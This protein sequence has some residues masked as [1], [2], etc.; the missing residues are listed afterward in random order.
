M[1]RLIFGLFALLYFW[2]ILPAQELSTTDKQQIE[3][4]GKIIDEND[5]AV[6]GATV[7]LKNTTVGTSADIDGM[8]KIKASKGDILNVTYLGYETYEFLIVEDQSNLLIQMKPSTKELDEVVVTGMGASQRKV[9]LVGAVTNVDVAQLQ[10]P[11][12]SLNNM[13]GGRV[14][15]VITRQ[16]SGEPGLD[17][18]EFWIRGIGTFGAGQGALVLIDGMEG[19][20]SDIDPADVESF[21]ILKDASA[22]A[23]YGVRG[24]N[25][26]V[27]VTTKKGV[28]GKISITA[29]TNYTISKMGRMPKYVDAY[30]YALLANEAN[31]VRGD[32]PVYSDFELDLIR[33]Q[34]DPDLYPNVNWQDE[35]MKDTGF[36]H[37]HYISA[38][39]GGS[40]ARYFVSLGASFDDS[41]YRID[42]NTKYKPSVGYNSYNYRSNIDMDITKTTNLYLGI[43][44]YVGVR[45]T[46]GVGGDTN[47]IWA[48]MARITPLM[49]PATYSDGKLP[50]VRYKDGYIR[51]P[52]AVMNYTGSGYEERSVNNISLALNQDLSA[53][54]EGLTARAQFAYKIEKND[55]SRRS[56][57]PDMYDALGRDYRTGAL[58]YDHVI[59][60]SGVDYAE[61]TD[62][63]RNLHFESTI[64]YTKTLKKKHRIGALAYYYMS[65]ESSYPNSGSMDAIA[66]RY[67][68]LS[69]RLSY[70]FKDTYLID[71]NFGYT[72]SENFEKGK[73]FGFFPSVAGGWVPTGY[74]IVKEKLPWLDFFKIRG[75]YG[76][77]GN[78]KITDTRFPFL[79]IIQQGGNSGWG[80]I[81]SV[82]ED[83][84]GA[85]NL[86]WEKAKKMDVGVEGRLFKQ[87]VDFTVD[88][89][90]DQRDG[91]FQER[92]Q[93]PDYV[94]LTSL[95]FGNVGRMRSYGAD[96]S[97]SYTH[98]IGKDMSFAIRGNFTH[99][100]NEIQEW[101]QVNQKYEYQEYKGWPHG[102]QRGYIAEGL[103][104]DEE[105]VKHSPI[106][107]FGKYAAG[108]IKY[109]DVNGDGQI[110][111]D[112]Q[113][114]LSYGDYP[115]LMYGFG[116][117]FKYKDF[118]I[119]ALFRGV[120]N[121]D[122][123]HISEDW[124][125]G[126][127]PFLDSSVGNV[128]EMVADQKNRWTPESY[129]GDKSTENP[130][131]KFP[132]LSYSSNENNKQLSTFW[133]SNSK[134]L[135][136]QEI[137]LSY[138]LMLPQ[139][140]KIGV[141]SMDLQLT[142]YD[143]YVWSDL[144]WD[145][146]LARYNGRRY[147][148]P[149]KYTFQLYVN[150]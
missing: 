78:D 51:S 111:G 5:E 144:E 134:H 80:G 125:M 85:N 68:G 101:E 49:V 52:Y 20:L 48:E 12:T 90:N 79:T 99:S 62:S 58:Q 108:D 74:D 6:I 73:Q 82:W 23:V 97:I 107:T 64:N 113:V 128:L 119:G 149:T 30:Q 87:S 140:Q 83:R 129:S 37:S 105:D 100:V 96:G 1:K 124:G 59:R 148:I 81:N 29:R 94:G 47:A 3:I 91:I 121:N 31:V 56:I 60:K 34:S 38:R 66:R 135:R 102:V 28:A 13:L 19:R 27:L 9:S 7:F 54:T 57:Q 143:L 93:I 131:A 36:Q 4:A 141:S 50:V 2:Q 69:G 110:N 17:V 139:L 136:L 130:N 24:A 104:K 122:F 25:G 21:S 22:T 126:Y 63:R 120:G 118:S 75:S 95:P 103:F 132:R 10:T 61:D 117:E 112:D 76:L 84:I 67:Q 142:G 16:T 114:P 106:Q 8:F 44:G 146:E 115:R 11:A 14:A 32:E 89:F 40:L 98:K 137:T 65:D 33:N 77:V 72:G 53:I 70:G 46:P 123:Y 150:F 127:V 35:L 138:R 26:V 147:P 39:G 86:Q 71:V 41:A 145:P 45:K 92:Q 133:K 116:G 88:I 15:G 42:K 55:W 18:S 109:K 43:D